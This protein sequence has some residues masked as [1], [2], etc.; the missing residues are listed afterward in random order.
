[1]PGN[2]LI[3]PTPPPSYVT[4]FLNPTYSSSFPTLS[5]TLFYVVYDYDC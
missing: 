2:S 5:P 3:S 4:E 1:M